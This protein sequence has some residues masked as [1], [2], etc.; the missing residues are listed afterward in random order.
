MNLHRL[1]HARAEEGRPVRVGL[2]GAGKFGT[3][4]LSQALHTPG[5]HVLGVADINVKRAQDNLAATHWPRHLYQAASGAEALAEGT[6]WVS[7]DAEALINISGLDVVVEATGDPDVGVRHALFAI[8]RGRHLVMVNVEADVIAGPYLAQKARKANVVYSLAY[9]DQPALIVELVDWARS[10]GLEV[11]AAGKGTLYM[12]EYHAINPDTV[13]EHYFS[14]GGAE[15]AREGG[16]N[17][18]MFTSF[19]DG[20][21]SAIEMAAV[22][23]ATGLTPA[24]AGLSFPA[25]AL[26]NLAC[27]LI[28][29]TAGGILHHKGQV[30][31]ISSRQR[32]GND[33]ENDLRWGVYVTFQAPTDYVERCFAD[34]GLI[35]DPGGQY[36]ALWRPYHLIGLELGPSVASAALLNLPT[37]APDAFRADVAAT[38][39]RDLKPGDVL[40]GEGGYTVWGR[41]M[42]AEDSMYLGA[43]PIGLAHGATLKNP[44]KEGCVVTWSDLELNLSLRE[45]TA[46][47]VR[48]EM[49]AT[50]AATPG[51]QSVS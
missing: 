8:E 44:V 16:M 38:A 33:L 35:T 30:E 50:M 23:N 48:R 31:V 3:M 14:E 9:G 46:Y 29:E 37:G 13:W 34:Y 2:I 24:P 27:T 42:L 19:I 49:E 11:V 7:D 43:V 18:K 26:E 5:L 45:S 12:P 51:V 36:S 39:K 40:D 25:C 6:T 20:T 47:R 17:A 1:L 4:F 10:C 15:R 28:P 32:D 21:K 22:S 41:L